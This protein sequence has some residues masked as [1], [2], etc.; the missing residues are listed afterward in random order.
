MRNQSD[1]PPFVATHEH[2]IIGHVQI[3]PSPPLPGPV[4]ALQPLRSTYRPADV[5]DTISALLTC[6]RDSEVHQWS[7]NFCDI[8]NVSST[9]SPLVFLPEAMK[10]MT[11]T[12]R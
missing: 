12:S 7:A 10:T 4:P 3:T 8:M 9:V 6:C 11:P 5:E 2:D 1:F